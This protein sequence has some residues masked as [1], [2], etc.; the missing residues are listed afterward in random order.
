MNGALVAPEDATISVF[1]HGIVAG[2][3]VFETILLHRRRPFALRRHLERLKRSADG[4]GIE[5]PKSSEVESAIDRVVDSCDFD[6]GRIRVIVTSGRGPLGSARGDG[7]ASLI[8]GR[9]VDRTPSRAGSSC[10]RPVV[11]QRVRGSCRAEDDLI[12]GERPGTPVRTRPGCRRG[13]L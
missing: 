10:R 8:V 2:D 9:G 6:T 1:D 11:P 5:A 12:R 13:D 7:P 4:L 3:G